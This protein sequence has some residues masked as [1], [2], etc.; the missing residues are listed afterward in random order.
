MNRLFCC[1]LLVSICLP[2]AVTA[3][4]IHHIDPR[5][6]LSSWKAQ[7][8][9]FSLELV[10]LM[11]DYVRAVYAS[12]GLPPELIAGVVKQCVF[13]TIVRNESDAPL[14]YRV[15]DWRYVTPDGVR[16]PLKTKSEWVQDWRKLGLAYRWSML[17]DEQTFEVGDWGQGFST[18]DLSPGSSFDLVYT[19]SQHE[20]KYTG[21][22][23]G[24]RCAPA[25]APSIP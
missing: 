3:E 16:H 2:D 21:T 4:A 6:G 10:Q 22:I 1:C 19:W 18:V 12:R 25:Q 13:G 15:S 20:K 14:S 9:G 17:P 23:K 11:P 5:T 8:A 24:V 7:E